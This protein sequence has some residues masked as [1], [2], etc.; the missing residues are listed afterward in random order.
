MG[1]CFRYASCILSISFY[2]PQAVAFRSKTLCRD[3]HPHFQLTI[4]QNNS[5][6]CGSCKYCSFYEGI[7][8]NKDPMYTP[9]KLYVRSRD[10]FIFL[11]LYLFSPRTDSAFFN[12][13]SGIN[14][15]VSNL[16]QN[17]LGD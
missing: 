6:L 7:S 15:V 3:I 11:C 10:I 16:N 12:C 17:E 8:Q 4:Q 9:M 1:R 5:I 13:H 2:D 14:K